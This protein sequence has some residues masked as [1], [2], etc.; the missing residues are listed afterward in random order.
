[1]TLESPSILTHKK[2]EN[3][4]NQQILMDLSQNRGHRANYYP[5]NGKGR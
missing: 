5:Q 4:E 3:T 1:M 2:V